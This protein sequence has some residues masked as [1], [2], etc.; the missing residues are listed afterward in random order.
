MKKDIINLSKDTLIYGAYQLLSRSIGI[1][2]APILTRIFSPG[3]YG[4]REIIFVTISF[5]TMLIGMNL[6]L[7]FSRFFFKKE[8][9][10]YRQLVFSS[11]VLMGFIISLCI[12]LIFLIF[13]DFFVKI[14][15]KEFK[16]E[17]YLYIYI[18]L[19][20]IPFI[21]ILNKMTTL[22]RLIKN[23]V[24][25]ASVNIFQV[26]LNFGLIILFVLVLRMGLTGAFIATTLATILTCFLGY[27]FTKDFFT[28]YLQF[29]V[30]KDMIVYSLP[31]FPAVIIH[32]GVKQSSKFF[33]I[34][35][36]SASALGIFSIANKIGILVFSL[37][38]VIRLGLDPFI[39]SI[40]DKKD[41]PQRT[42]I[43]YEYALV[44]FIGISVLISIFAKEI[45]MILAPPQ[46]Y[47]AIKIVPII[48]FGYNFFLITHFMSFR[49]YASE[50]TKYQSYIMV[51]VF[52]IIMLANYFLIPLWGIL[53]CALVVYLGYFTNIIG[54]S[55][56]AKKVR[57][58][59]Y[60]IMK[61]M[62]QIILFSIL[63]TILNYLTLAT[64]I[65]Y[66]SNILITIFYYA[67]NKKL[68]DKIIYEA[69]CVIKRKYRLIT[70]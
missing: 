23:K 64:Y 15:F 67:A 69:F 54:Q 44:F 34:F 45:V 68:V 63:F 28:K 27:F 11:S 43:I 9:I 70:L 1:L 65:I 35:F 59:D 40:M 14:F 3:E 10:K 16:K 6:N 13:Q 39:F 62:L 48:I 18:A 25:F 51:G 66:I 5:L 49:I 20:S 17:Y 24:A 12:I 55:I 2:I 22:L 7:G 33:L 41:F 50:K 19:V 31:A 38:G 56:I 37:I 61:Y 8:D 30:L 26:I 29:N 52:V 57:E 4:T 36:L 60:P 58:I 21:S 53:G 32:W 42:I 47:D 46:Y